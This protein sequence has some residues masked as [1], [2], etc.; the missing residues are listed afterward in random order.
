M[1]RF[2]TEELATLAAYEGDAALSIY[3]PMYEA[4]PEQMQ[5][6]IRFKNALAEAEKA[7]VDFGCDEALRPQLRMLSDLID[8]EEFWR[9]QQQGLVAFVTPDRV[10][11]RRAPFH[12]PNSVRVGRTFF[13]LPLVPLVQTS[14]L[15]YI[16]AVSQK[17]TRLLE[18]TRGEISEVP[19]ADLPESLAKYIPVRQKQFTLGSFNIRK[20]ASQGRQAVPAGHP[21]ERDEGE[22]RQFFNDINEAVTAVIA[23][24]D[25][26]LVFAG[27]EELFPFYK[28][29]NS[30]RGLVGE[31]IFGNP[32]ETDNKEL[33]AAAWPMVKEAME[34]PIADRVAKLGHGKTE[35]MATDNLTE[36]IAA[37][38]QGQVD[39]LLINGPMLLGHAP[40]TT[41]SDETVDN[42]GRAD[43]AVRAT[44]AASGDVFAVEGEHVGGHVAAATLR[45]PLNATAGV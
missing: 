29:A 41:P 20:G 16:V 33:H 12:F 1:A 18:A 38:R 11:M 6:G 24:Q 32:D 3:L 34:Q 21:E 19:E 30:H 45:Y 15:F 27:V 8:D 13:L 39:T 7:A 10:D 26:P 2:T 4:G 31:A 36:V 35:Q 28:E 44:L 23:D 37:A 40:G 9:H 17:H 25:A 42:R 43:E 14:G 22:L 5:N